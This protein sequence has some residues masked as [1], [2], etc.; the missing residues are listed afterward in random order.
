MPQDDLMRLKENATDRTLTAVSATSVPDST[1]DESI[2]TDFTLDF[3][4]DQTGD[5]VEIRA[6]DIGG[7]DSPYQVI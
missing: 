7:P 2:D 4:D 1:G 6:S 5:P 3:T